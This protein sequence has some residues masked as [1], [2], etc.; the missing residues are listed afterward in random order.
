MIGRE[1][2]ESSEFRYDTQSPQS[3]VRSDNSARL[4]HEGK[5]IRRPFLFVPSFPGEGVMIEEFLYL[6]FRTFLLAE[7]RKVASEASE[8]SQAPFA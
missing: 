4:L 1:R 8:K 6:S 3:S 7:E 2:R 5:L